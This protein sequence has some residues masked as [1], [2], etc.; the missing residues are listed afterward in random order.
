MKKENFRDKGITLIALVV[1]II[2]LLVLAGVTISLVMRNGGII[3]R[4]K[5]SGEK[6]RIGQERENIN[7][8][9][10]QMKIEDYAGAST[11]GP[12]SSTTTSSET[13]SS[14]S[15]SGAIYKSY[16]DEEYANN[17]EIRDLQKN[18]P[19]TYAKKQILSSSD[20]TYLD[21][22]YSAPLNYAS[23]F[24]GFNGSKV[25]NIKTDYRLD[26]SVISGYKFGANLA[27]S[28]DG[29]KHVDMY[30]KNNTDETIDILITGNN[31]VIN[32]VGSSAPFIS[33]SQTIESID[34]SYWS[35]K[36]RDSLSGYLGGC[37]NL[38]TVI[39]DSW[40][41]TGRTDGIGGFL[42]G[43]T[44]LTHIN[45][46]G[47]LFDSMQSFAGLFSGA[48]NLESVDWFTVKGNTNCESLF[49]QTG[50]NGTKISSID[51]ST[52]ELSKVTS[53]A[54][55]FNSLDNVTK[56]DFSKKDLK[57]VEKVA[58]LFAGSKK[59]ESIDMTNTILYN[60]DGR[61]S[62]DKNTS[63]KGFFNGLTN[64]KEVKMFT[65]L[66][67]TSF[68]HMLNNAFG[69]TQ[70]KVLDLNS[71]DASNVTDLQYCFQ[72]WEDDPN[73]LE[74]IDLSSWDTSNVEN[75]FQTF[76]C[77]TNLKTIY[78]G[79]KWN[80]SNFEKQTN[81]QTFNLDTKLVG[82]NGT[83]IANNPSADNP[84]YKHD[85]KTD[86]IYAVADGKDGKVGYL[87]YK[88]Y[89]T[90]NWDTNSTTGS[91][92]DG[93]GFAARLQA[94][95]N[96]TKE[97]VVCS[98]EGDNTCKVVFNESKRNYLINEDKYEIKK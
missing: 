24:T 49:L 98:E 17:D 34:L 6:S 65:L 33:G 56:I 29:S 71:W 78:V 35:I 87:T 92:T 91:S 84:I 15:S 39:V 22:S 37:P 38:K 2:V 30:Y 69:G 11:Q 27:K 81:S 67:S 16:Y 64:L 28:T 73:N 68:A 19:D 52:W 76:Y 72:G 48:T 5:G 23:Y 54:S 47:W 94:I 12:K 20:I 63:F 82:G 43:N 60:Y 32:D 18:H 96:K 88:Q 62:E 50:I 25:K 58:G 95:M 70:V 1:T 26:P 42:G 66:G 97:I 36:N 3:D 89:V 41:M 4:A 86:C 7:L 53:I 57:N 79:D 40:D 21:W 45:L 9:L 46:S 85:E 80:S 44:S 10:G 31:A 77:N 14:S 75:M 61:F 90:Q 8:A 83:T 93:E 13:T 55:L 59:L 51:V 74:V